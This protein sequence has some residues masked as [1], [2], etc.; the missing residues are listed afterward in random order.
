MRWMFV[1]AMAAITAAA[2][3]PAEK[4]VALKP[5]PGLEKV[6]AHCGACHSL[7]YIPMN[8]R[9]LD[10]AGWNTEVAKMI[11]A[12]GAPVDQTDAKAIAE[13]LGANYGSPPQPGGPPAGASK[14]P[15]QGYE[16]ADIRPKGPAAR[17]LQRIRIQRS[18]L[19]AARR[20]PEVRDPFASLFAMFEPRTCKHRA[21][22]GA[23]ET[24]RASDFARRQERW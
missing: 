19:H 17:P 9:F 21:R 11:N 20:R 16:A 15:R 4:P 22:T 7:D 1:A 13:Y 2:A 24:W 8:A 23:C 5:G 12:F 18:G 14:P 10:V 3:Q 6:V